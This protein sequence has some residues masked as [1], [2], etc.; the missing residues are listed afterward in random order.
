MVSKTHSFLRCGFIVTTMIAF[1]AAFVPSKT[2]SAAPTAGPTS[3]IGVTAGSLISQLQQ[4]DRLRAVSLL[5]YSANRR[6]QVTSDTGKLRSETQV[7]LQYQSPDSKQFKIV[8]E[9]GPAMLRSIIKSL[10]TFETEAALG[11]GD[12]DS[13]I[14]PANYTFQLAGKDSVD[15][16]KCFV[17]QAS[18]KRK[19]KYLFEGR[20]WIEEKEFAIVKI[21][22]RPANRP[23]FSIKSADFTRHYQRIGGTWLPLKD[24]T[25][26]QV[27]LFGENVLTIDHGDYKLSVR[28]ESSLNKNQVALFDWKEILELKLTNYFSGASEQLEQQSGQQETL[29]QPREGS[30]S[31]GRRVDAWPAG[32]TAFREASARG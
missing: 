28:P 17:V 29:S 24:Q 27:R 30:S 19:D 3:N 26:S 16:Y 8:S 2:E 22:G 31:V 21:V 10:L 23:S 1:S 6:Y 9:S 13:S 12:R 7:S 25:V 4:H 15:G 11:R 18:P 20:I 5:K 32:D 14:T